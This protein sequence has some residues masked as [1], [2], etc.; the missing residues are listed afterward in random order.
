MAM[1]DLK[2]CPFCG[3]PA[4]L[5]HLGGPGSTHAWAECSKCE[6]SLPTSSTFEAAAVK[7]NSRKEPSREA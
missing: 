7:W 3:A 2:P 5:H 6:A 1:P 4:R